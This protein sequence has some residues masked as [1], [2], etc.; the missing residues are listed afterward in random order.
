M[1]DGLIVTQSM[2]ARWNERWMSV[3][4]PKIKS[5]EGREF[6]GNGIA[7]SWAWLTRSGRDGLD[8]DPIR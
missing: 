3:L 1:A 6:L 7:G 8:D 2:D 4:L 5:A